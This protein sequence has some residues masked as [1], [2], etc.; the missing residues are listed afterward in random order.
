MGLRFVPLSFPPGIAFRRFS[1]RFSKVADFLSISFA[2]EKLFPGNFASEKLRGRFLRETFPRQ[3]RDRF[4]FEEFLCRLNVMPKTFP[5]LNFF[6]AKTF[7]ANVA[8]TFFSKT[9]F[10][11]FPQIFFPQKNFSLKTSRLKLSQEKTFSKIIFR[12]IKK[13]FLFFQNIFLQK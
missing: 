2:R 9:F 5:R 3:L 7:S 10:G 13:H 11:N 8:E 6:Q 12:K 1:F 4:F